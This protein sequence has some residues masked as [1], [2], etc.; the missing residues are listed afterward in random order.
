MASIWRCISGTCLRLRQMC[1]LSLT[2]CSF[3]SLF[4]P[5]QRPE[6]IEGLLDTMLR[7]NPPVPFVFAMAADKAVIPEELVQRVQQSGR[8]FISRWVPQVEVLRHD[9][10]GAFLVRR[11][12]RPPTDPLDALRVGI[13]H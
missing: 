1:D 6:I 13:H 3:G 7:R 2:S 10:V 12:P 4:W 8:G 9:A 5:T 11:S